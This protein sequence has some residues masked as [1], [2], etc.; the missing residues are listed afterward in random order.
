MTESET[1]IYWL[2]ENTPPTASEVKARPVHVKTEGITLTE[3][4]KR[5]GWAVPHQTVYKY[6]SGNRN[7][8]PDR[9]QEMANATNHPVTVRVGGRLFTLQPE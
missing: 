4:G 3:L 9:G 8:T 5:C 6:A 7:L 1:D 2:C